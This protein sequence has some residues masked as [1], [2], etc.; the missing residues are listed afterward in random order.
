MLIREISGFKYEG[1]SFMKN[2]AKAF[3][4]LVCLFLGFS[5][6]SGKKT[7]YAVW[8]QINNK[9]ENDYNIAMSF[10]GKDL[11]D[12]APLEA[13][14]VF[15]GTAGDFSMADSEFAEVIKKLEIK[16]SDTN[17]EIVLKQEFSFSDGFIV[18]RDEND[19]P[20]WFKR[21]EIKLFLV[22]N[23]NEKGEISL[24]VSDEDAKDENDG[25]GL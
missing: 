20:F 6:C 16:V 10:K 18:N 21:N 13:G 3:A 4:L 7:R 17:S 8:V 14:F 1:E 25:L 11:F 23:K 2:R 5:A 12:Q 19:V 22:L 24:R 15:E 9:T